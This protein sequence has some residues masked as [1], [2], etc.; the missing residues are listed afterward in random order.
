MTMDTTLYE[1]LMRTSLRFVSYR[2]RS[3][4]ELRDFIHKKLSLWKTYASPGMAEKIIG[5]TRELGYV[6]DEKFAAWWIDQ[7][8][9]FKLKG[10]R[11]IARELQA[12]GVGEDIVERLL[13]AITSEKELATRAIQKKLSLWSAVP[14]MEKKQKI[15]RYLAGRG[16]DQEAISSVIDLEEEKE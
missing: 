2:P 11:L 12:K 6:D 8:R 14:A 13:S 16:F 3:E 5:R 7:R 9:T 1:R 15:Y 10:N 4:K